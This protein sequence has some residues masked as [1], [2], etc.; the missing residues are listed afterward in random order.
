MK[1]TKDKRRKQVNRKQQEKNPQLPNKK[2]RLAHKKKKLQ[3]KMK[4]LF[5]ELGL[6][7][8]ITFFLLIIIQQLTFSLTKIEGYSMLNT[9]M[10][11]DRVLVNK[12]SKVKRFD[13]VYYRDTKSNEMAVR[14]IIGLPKEQFYY[15]EDQLFVEDKRVPERFLVEIMKTSRNDKKNSTFTKDFGLQEVTGDQ[16]IPE[17]K[18]FVLGD[19]RPYAS[20]SR[21]LG[22]IDEKDIVGVVKMRVMPFH[23]IQSF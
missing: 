19:N 9:L 2:K 1:S 14:R 23:Q 6:T 22:Y 3:K 8:L 7:I 12:L 21:E 17:G 20:D 16:R 15:R 5:Q 10:D 4:Q 13:L 18:Y 11:N